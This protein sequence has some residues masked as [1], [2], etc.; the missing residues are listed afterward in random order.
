MVFTVDVCGVS[1]LDVYA[2]D[3]SIV[4]EYYTLQKQCK[5]SAKTALRPLTQLT[6]IGI[7]WHIKVSNS[8]FDSDPKALRNGHDNLGEII[9]LFPKI[10]LKIQFQ[11]WKMSKEAGQRPGFLRVGERDTV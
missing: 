4:A 3:Q 2:K 10:C 1:L 5:N 9:Q 8:Y 11:T 7:L 6:Q